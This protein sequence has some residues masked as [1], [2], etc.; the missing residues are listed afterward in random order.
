MV[1]SKTNLTFVSKAPFAES[2]PTTASSGMT[3]GAKSHR[4]GGGGFVGN[5]AIPICPGQLFNKWPQEP[6]SRVT[7]VCAI[8]LSRFSRWAIASAVQKKNRHKDLQKDLFLF[9]KVNLRALCKQKSVVKYTDNYLSIYSES[10]VT[11]RSRQR[12]SIVE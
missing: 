3:F 4:E 2:L 12:L 10:K 6:S 8:K 1:H 9:R 7:T 11:S 5:S